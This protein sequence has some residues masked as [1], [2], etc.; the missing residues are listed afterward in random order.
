M[1]TEERTAYEIAREYRNMGFSVIP[2]RADGSKAPACKW[3]KYQTKPATSEEIIRWWNTGEVLGIGIVGGAAS[4]NLTILDIETWHAYKRWSRIVDEHHDTLSETLPRVL[5]PSGGVHIYFR[6]NQPADKNTK[7]AK[8]DHGNCLIET[9]GE[10]GY[11]LA[12]GS[13]EECHTNGKKYSKLSGMSI[14]DTPTI[15]QANANLILDA[16]RSLDSPRHVSNRGEGKEVGGKENSPGTHYNRV[17]TWDDVLIPAG[18]SKLN[19]Q[20]NIQYWRRP[21]KEDGV[22][23]TTGYCKTETNDDL[24]YVFST[25]AHPFE[26]RTYSKFAAMTLL[27]YSGDFKASAQALGKAGLGDQSRRNGKASKN[28]SVENEVSEFLE[29]MKDEEEED[30]TPKPT[31]VETLPWPSYCFPP[32][33]SRLIEDVAYQSGCKLDFSGLGFMVFAG[34]AIGASRRLLMTSPGW[35]E[36]CNIYAAIVAHP[37]S[38]KSTPLKFYNRY[39]STEQEKRIREFQ[40]DIKD[41]KDRLKRYEAAVKR[42]DET[43]GR[44]PE[45]P[46]QVNYFVSDCTIERLIAMLGQNPRGIFSYQDELSGWVQAMDGYKAK[47]SGNERQQYMTIWS[48]GAIKKDRKLDEDEGSLI[49]PFPFLSI[50]GTVQPDLIKRLCGNGGGKDGWLD[51]FIWTYEPEYQPKPITICEDRDCENRWNEVANALLNFLKMDSKDGM[52]MPKTVYLSDGAKLYFLKWSERNVGRQLHPDFP[53]A[54]RGPMEKFKSYAGRFALLL[55]LLKVAYGFD[56][57]SDDVS[58]ETMRDA[59]LLCDYFESQATA[60]YCEL[61]QQEV[62]NQETDVEKSIKSLLKRM[63]KKKIKSISSSDAVRHCSK[64]RNSKQAM[65]VFDEMKS[66]GYGNV[67]VEKTGGKPKTVFTAKDDLRSLLAGNTLP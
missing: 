33:V 26:V 51:R 32:E 37:G 3:Q 9:R 52:P 22:S 28:G 19:R 43:I 23:A 64:I 63:E 65:V 31:S 44:Q 39:F 6:T 14:V 58:A 42:K 2:I 66:R 13:P 12:P 16:A 17:A 29:G 40:D 47:G 59:C 48:G 35:F 15:S 20:D 54:M 11:V 45:K 34:A 46:T 18:W 1:Q 61:E 21:G 53:V 56:S 62:Y 8:D 55:H 60:I 36:M 38:G 27:Q 57:E 4:G 50:I 49:A 41:Y 30:I 5:T 24:L 67:S 25:N 10:G 7:L